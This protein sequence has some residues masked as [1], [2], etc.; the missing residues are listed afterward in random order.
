MAKHKVYRDL[1]FTAGDSPI[2]IDI[3]TDLGIS[4][5]FIL[6]NDGPGNIIVEIEYPNNGTW[7]EPLA[8]GNG[9]IYNVSTIKA[10]QVRLSLEDTTIPSRYALV[11]LAG[12][13]PLFS[14][15][16]QNRP[17]VNFPW[18]KVRENIEVVQE[19]ENGTNQAK[20]NYTVPT[21]KVLYIEALGNCARNDSIVAEWQANG[22]GFWS[23]C[24]GEES[25]NP[26]IGAGNSAYSQ[27][28]IRNPLGPFSAGTVV[29][30]YRV[31]G[32]TG[33]EWASN[34]IGYLEKA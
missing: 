34:M 12:G 23:H 33:S 10:K 21:G 18:Y 27:M 31:A 14:R 29:R 3:E 9:E 20:I 30:A 28:P 17:V 24:V 16:P 7:E 6:V 32:P 4:S 25:L 1:D 2:I 13:N 5:G 11:A 26:T 15:D 8:I 22:T 19:Y